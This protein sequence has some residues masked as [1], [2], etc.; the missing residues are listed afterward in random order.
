MP[1][2]PLISTE[3]TTPADQMVGQQMGSSIVPSDANIRT[4]FMSV[5]IIAALGILLAVRNPKF[6]LQIMV[7]TL[8]AS[9]GAGYIAMTKPSQYSSSSTGSG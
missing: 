1:V 3:A 8:G 7:G 2:N 5:G 6:V 9:V 4:A